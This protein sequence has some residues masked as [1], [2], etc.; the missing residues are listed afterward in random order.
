MTRPDCRSHIVVVTH[1]RQTAPSIEEVHNLDWLL[2]P[3]TSRK[4]ASHRAKLAVIMHQSEVENSR[5]GVWPSLSCIFIPDH[6]LRLVLLVNYRAQ[7]SG[8]LPNE[9]G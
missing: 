2:N 1:K 8:A 9:A 6:R 4:R 7:I 3:G 5:R